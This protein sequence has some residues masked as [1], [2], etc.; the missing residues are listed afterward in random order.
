MVRRPDEI[1]EWR[2]AH[3]D[4]Y[5]RVP[6]VEMTRRVAS[7]LRAAAT[8]DGDGLTWIQAEHRVRPN[9]VFAQTGLMQRAAGTGLYCARLDAYERGRVPFVPLSDTPFV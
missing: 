1:H 3:G 9:E 5:A 8:R 2:L 6:H 4:A 7:R